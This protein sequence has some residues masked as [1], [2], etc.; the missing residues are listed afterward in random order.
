MLLLQ[1]WRVQTFINPKTTRSSTEIHHIVE[2][3]VLM[4]ARNG[5][6]KSKKKNTMFLKYEFCK[7]CKTK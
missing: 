7:T 1:D 3:R 4:I 5:R 2:G 6:G